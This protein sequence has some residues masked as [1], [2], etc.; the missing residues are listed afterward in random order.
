MAEFDFTQALTGL[1]SN[2]GNY[3]MQQQAAKQQA[4]LISRQGMLPQL[5]M[6]YGGMAPQ[7]RTPGMMYG[8][9]AG[10]QYPAPIGPQLPPGSSTPSD[11]FGLGGTP[12]GSMLGYAN[13]AAAGCSS[14][15][16][17]P[18]ANPRPRPQQLVMQPNPA[19]GRMHF[20]RHVGSPI[21]YSG[22]VSHCK[23]VE[24][25]LGRARGKLHRGRR[26]PR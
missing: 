3:F 14:L 13:P 1:V 4:K 23:T 25:I 19:T 6:G 15:F 26:R 7:P 22:D 9:G 17:Q 12:L 24:R 5:G 11:P 21:L 20:W 16:V 18:T 8:Y 10:Y 2:V